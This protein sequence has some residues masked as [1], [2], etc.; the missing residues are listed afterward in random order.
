MTAVE[1]ASV[2][3]LWTPNPP[4]KASWHFLTIDPQTAMEIRYE[5]LGRAR[6]FGSIRVSAT[7]G[8]TV[9][10]TSIF[11]HKESGG[12]ILPVKADVRRAEGIGEGD[13][14]TVRLEV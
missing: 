7:I 3:W 13:H 4:A 11:P 9:W 1:I 8:E 10:Q 12:F 14:V 6:G 2:L 5:A